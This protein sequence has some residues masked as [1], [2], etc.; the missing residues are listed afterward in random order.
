[1]PYFCLGITSPPDID[2]TGAWQY[3]TWGKKTYY[4]F[5][6]K[7]SHDPPPP[8][9]K[10]HPIRSRVNMIFLFIFNIKSQPNPHVDAHSMFHVRN[11]I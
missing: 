10:K 1:M 2:M 5:T 3:P 4:F 8:S 11:A 9:E 7:N 6:N